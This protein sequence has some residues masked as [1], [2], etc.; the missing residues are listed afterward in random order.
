MEK[1]P[2]GLKQHVHE[3][4][5]MSQISKEGLENIQSFFSLP[6]FLYLGASG[7]LEVVACDALHLG[8]DVFVFEAN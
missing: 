7:F 3:P 1:E 8:F 6:Q 2:K 4:D 5:Y